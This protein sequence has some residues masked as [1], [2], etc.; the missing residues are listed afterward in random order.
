[1]INIV[2]DLKK[3][4][5]K[6]E[7]L[8]KMNTEY[9][10]NIGKRDNYFKEVIQSLNNHR[11][12]LKN[13]WGVPNYNYSTLPSVEDGDNINDYKYYFKVVF[14][15]HPSANELKIIEDITG[16]RFSGSG[17]YGYVFYFKLPE[18][19]SYDIRLLGESRNGLSNNLDK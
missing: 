6:D 19:I 18:V 10:I 11:E 3:V 9:I 13:D 17:H 7:A 4:I 1:M 14:N 16:C 15:H 8:K 5:E 12:E 2:E